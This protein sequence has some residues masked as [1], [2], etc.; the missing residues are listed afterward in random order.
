M[1]ER[2]KRSISLSPEDLNL[3]RHVCAELWRRGQRGTLSAAVRACLKALR[4]AIQ[5]ESLEDLAKKI[6]NL[7]TETS[8]G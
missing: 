7:A 8:R 4:R 5:H 1:G 2:Q 3:L 6:V